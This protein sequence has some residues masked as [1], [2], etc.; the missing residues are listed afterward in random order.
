MGLN[1][2]RPP[3]RTGHVYDTCMTRMTLRDTYTY[4]FQARRRYRRV[5]RRAASLPT[6]PPTNLPT[7][8]LTYQPTYP[9]PTN[10]PNPHLVSN[11]CPLYL[12]YPSIRKPWFSVW[13]VILVIQLYIQN[14]PNPPP[15]NQQMH[16]QRNF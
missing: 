10:Q 7:P 14:L 15:T 5:H 16:L 2:R 12:T 3:A 8:H 11:P 1:L 4:L 6:H 13:L 9:P